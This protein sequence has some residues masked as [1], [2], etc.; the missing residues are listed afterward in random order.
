MAPGAGGSRWRHLTLPMVGLVVLAGCTTVP[1]SAER[2]ALADTLA[3]THSWRRVSMPTSE[4]RLAA[5]L[6]EKASTGDRLTVYLE[7]DGFAWESPSRPSADPT[8]LS[9]MGLKLA[10][11][12]FRSSAGAGPVAYLARPCQFTTELDP[13]CAEMFWT[14][15]RFAP[16]VVDATSQAMDALKARSGASRLRLVGYSGGGALAT[17]LAARRNDVTELVTVAGNLD[18]RAWTRH[19]RLKPLD[20]S[21]N[22]ADILATI[23]AVPQWHF[24]GPGDRVV[25]AELT[26]DLVASMPAGSPARFILVPEQDHHCCWPDVWPQL[27]AE[28]P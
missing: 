1:P 8:P 4:F 7:G 28:L 17:L 20:G 11:A 15:W 9:P 21:L 27:L 18:H 3:A 19:H 25:P 22:P 5:Y 16:Q 14:E 13:A 10:L 6:P 26:R 23:A 24:A 12:D 2:L